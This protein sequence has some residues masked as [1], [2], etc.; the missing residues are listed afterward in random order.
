MAGVGEE[1]QLAAV[2]ADARRQ[3]P[4]WPRLQRGEG[5]VGAKGGRGSFGRHSWSR[6]CAQAMETASKN[7]TRRRWRQ[8]RGGTSMA[9]ARGWTTFK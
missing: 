7:G 2:L 3:R 4:W 1:G 5:A 9:R 8:R 6:G